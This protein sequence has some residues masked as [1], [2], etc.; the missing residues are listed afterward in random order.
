MNKGAGQWWQKGKVE[1]LPNCEEITGEYI[2]KRDWK[3]DPKGYF[4]IRVDAKKKLLEVAYCPEV[5]KIGLIIRGR[6]PN[7]CHWNQNR[8]HS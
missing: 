2:A 4:L 6:R 5:N 7:R 3:M 8:F 1:R